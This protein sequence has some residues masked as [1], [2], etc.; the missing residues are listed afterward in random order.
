MKDVNLQKCLQPVCPNARKTQLFH[1][2]DNGFQHLALQY[3]VNSKSTQQNHI[4]KISVQKLWPIFISGQDVSTVEPIVSDHVVTDYL[5]TM[6][7]LTVYWRKQRNR[8][9]IQSISPLQ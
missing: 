3:T 6:F 9:K 8:K 7:S 2:A 4:S 1:T 5:H